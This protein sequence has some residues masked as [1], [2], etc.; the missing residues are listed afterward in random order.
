MK[1][2]GKPLQQ[3]K[4]LVGKTSLK[5]SKPL[6]KVS[7]TP[8]KQKKPM[9]SKLKKRA[10]TIFSKAIRFRDGEIIEGEWIVDCITCDARKPFKAMQAG[11][12]QSRRY[13]ATRF[14][15]EN[16][17]A[18]CYRC[19]VMFYGEQYK[20]SQAIDMKYGGGVAARL[21]K[22]AL[23]PHPFTVEELQ[24][25]INN[26]TEEVTYYESLTA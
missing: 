18:Q 15:Y 7:K 5:A 8:T 12:F 16:V 14:D 21:E 1:R 10:D 20:Y 24:D 6:Q 13:N 26:A 4:A 11:H 22:Q 25:I 17:N 9:V 19:N 23:V 2:S 3:K